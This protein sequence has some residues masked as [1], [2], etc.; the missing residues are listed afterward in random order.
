MALVRLRSFGYSEP[1]IAARMAKHQY[2][3]EMYGG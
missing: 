3:V 1:P 2:S